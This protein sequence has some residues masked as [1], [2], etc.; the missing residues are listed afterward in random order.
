MTRTDEMKELMENKVLE[1]AR[2]FKNNPNDIIEY[3]KFQS[4]FYNYSYRNCTL[5]FQQN[6]GAL[7]CNSYKKFKEIG[8]NVKK[9]EHGMKILVPA[10]KK[11]IKVNDEFIPLASA[12]PEQKKL[13]KEN[14]LEVKE[15][16]FFKVGTVFDIA[17]TTCPT[18]DYPKYLDLG[19]S[20]KKHKDL[21]QSLKT[22]SEKEFNCPV[23][24]NSF[25]SVRLR[26]YYEPATNQI[27]I[28]GNFDDTTKLSILSHELGH[29]VMHKNVQNT[30]TYQV[31]FEADAYSIMLQHYCGIEIPESR[32]R[33]CAENLKLMCK[34]NGYE[35]QVQKSLDTAHTAFKNTVNVINKELRPEMTKSFDNNISPQ[36][37]NAPQNNINQQ[38]ILPCQI[39]NMGMGG[40]SF[41]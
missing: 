26:G 34:Q 36:Q 6:P 18:A 22:Y 14:K 10:P 33:H 1:L 38:P 13:Y 37:N 3:L 5:I 24:E 25:S 27:L 31:E 2:N 29:A 7:F 8:Y 41:S 30:S 16:L 21:F 35:K 11:F 17:Q 9:G 23:H 32:I 19:Y 15:K 12:T 39:P 4:K 20:S 40:M 28:S